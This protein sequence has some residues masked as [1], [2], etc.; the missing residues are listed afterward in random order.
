[1]VESLAL[2]IAETLKRIEPD[3][4]A[5]VAVMKFSLEAIINTA[6]TIL[7]ISIVGLLTNSIGE[8][9]LGVAGFALLRFFSGGLHL[10]EAL[11]CSII[12]VILISS[13]PH[14]P[15]NMEWVYYTGI[16]SVV[17]VL[18]FTPSNMEGYAR[19]PKKYFPLLK[20]IST[21]IVS[22]NFIFGSSTI[23]IVFLIQSIT[24]ITFKK[25]RR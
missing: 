20:I 8:T 21:L 1:M 11:H 16:I 14:I 18:L 13:A 9:M 6:F 24:T 4:T 7:F 22:L 17:I 10:R 12:S 25:R 23:A 19:I 2:R 15:L 5:S 3:R